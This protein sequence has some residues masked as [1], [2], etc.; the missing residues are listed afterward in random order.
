MKEPNVSAELK[1][2]KENYMDLYFPDTVTVNS[3][4]KGFVKYYSTFDTITKKLF[5]GEDTLRMITLYTRKNKS[6]VTNNIEELLKTV[7]KD[8]FYPRKSDI[9]NNNYIIHFEQKFTNVGKCYLE[10]LFRDEVYFLENSPLRVLT[11]YSYVS[12]PV[13]VIDK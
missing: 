12:K 6:F 1:D 13:Y 7:A 11:K 8:S 2:L 5:E 4:N 9:D 10:G 3:T